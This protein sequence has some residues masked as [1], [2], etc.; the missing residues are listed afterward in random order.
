MDAQ[1]VSDSSCTCATN[2]QM[3][4]HNKPEN[5]RTNKSFPCSNCHCP[6]SSMMHTRRCT[7]C[8]HH[9]NNA[10]HHLHIRQFNYWYFLLCVLSMVTSTVSL[11]SIIIEDQQTQVGHFFFYN[12]STNNLP[13][14]ELSKLKVCYY[15]MLTSMPLLYQLALIMLPYYVQSW[16]HINLFICH[17]THHHV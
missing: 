16:Y 4:I 3:R 10:L 1:Q 13:L 17:H 12:I 2:S 15:M 6:L 11:E 7:K 8:N 9:T 5:K 14:K